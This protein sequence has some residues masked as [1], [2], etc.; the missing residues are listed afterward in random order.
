M[1]IDPR[2]QFVIPF[3]HFIQV[4][5]NWIG[6][7]LQSKW[8]KYT[9]QKYLPPSEVRRRMPGYL[10]NNQ[11][12]KPP[13]N[14]LFTDN[15]KIINTQFEHIH[16]LV[17]RKYM[18][19]VWGWLANFLQPPIE[20]NVPNRPYLPKHKCHPSD[21]A[22]TIRRKWWPHSIRP[23]ASCA[24]Y[25]ATSAATPGNNEMSRRWIGM[26]RHLSKIDYYHSR[27]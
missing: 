24:T 13:W 27:R 18:V 20:W 16:Y 1:R 15:F 17:Q 6:L 11:C 19:Q 14:I 23:S 4:I 2:H 26:V 25:V 7:Q 5:C 21:C 9:W 22:A 10:W 8:I 3:A 12:G